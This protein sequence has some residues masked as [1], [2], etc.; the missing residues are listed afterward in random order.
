MS[1]AYPML[2]VQI[3]LATA[4]LWFTFK[5]EH[6]ILDSAVRKLKVQVAKSGKMTG[7][8][9]SAILIFVLVFLGWV[10]LSPTIGLGVVALIG[11]VLYLVFGLI[12][13]DDLNRNTGVLFYFSERQY[14]WECK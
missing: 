1:Y 3:P 4:I 9:I 2:L 13:W 14:Q 6:R 12:H 5:P 7:R 8:E 11:V 10:F